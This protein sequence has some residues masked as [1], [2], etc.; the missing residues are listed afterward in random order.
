MFTFTKPDMG[1]DRKVTVHIWSS[2][3]G[4]G[5]VSMETYLNGG[6]YISYWP[7]G[8][9]SNS[10]VLPT[11]H[12][13]QTRQHD[14]SCYDKCASYDIYDLDVEKIHTVFNDFARQDCGFHLLAAVRLMNSKLEKISNVQCCSTLVYDLLRTGNLA[15]YVPDIDEVF[16]ITVQDQNLS[17]LT[18]LSKYTYSGV[19]AVS[20]A[21]QTVARAGGRNPATALVGGGLALTALGLFV[22]YGVTKAV[23]STYDYF[24]THETLIKP[25]AIERIAIKATSR[26]AISQSIKP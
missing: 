21:G 17:N 20:H 2:E 11:G 25:D 15:R 3:S 8:Q 13:L 6:K 18:K 24:S 4:F 16:N 22:A 5:H 19:S 26:Q 1:N 9:K 10:N 14:S 12:S 7:A 23:S